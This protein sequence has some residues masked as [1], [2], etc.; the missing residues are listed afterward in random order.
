MRF[1]KFLL[2]STA[3]FL[4]FMTA[5]FVT[6]EI[7]EPKAYNYMV[8]TFTAHKHG[9]SRIALIVI[10]DK[11]IGR[12]RWPWKRN[13]YCGIYDYFRE[14]TNAKVVLSDSIVTSIDDINA[15]KEYF[16]SISKSDNLIVGI[17]FRGREYNNPKIGKQYDNKINSKFKSC[18]VDKRQNSKDYPFR[19]ASIFPDGYLNSVK[20][21]GIITSITATDG[22]IRVAINAINYKG[23][24]Y[25]SISL[26]AYS[27]IN[28]DEQLTVT[29]NYITGEKSGLKIPLINEKSGMYSLIKFYKLNKGS[30]SYSHKTYSAVDIMDS[31]KEL[32]SG[33][34]P[35]IDPKEFDNKYIFVG[36]NVKAAA[37]GLS[38][39][40]ETPMSSDHSGL[41]LQ[42]TC[43]DNLIN[44][45][46][47]VELPG[48]LNLLISFCL[49]ILSFLTIRNFSLFPAILSVSGITI[50]YIA[51]CA[52]LFRFGIAIS[53]LTPISMVIITM[54]FAYSHK[55]ILED[56]NKE[57]IKTAMGKYISEDIMKNVVKNIDEIKL[58]GKKAN[59]TVL[60]ADIRGFTS[61]SEK[62]T[63]DE[64]SLILNEYFTEIEPIVTKNNGVINKFIGDAVMAIFGE[65]IQDEN[66]PKNAVRC[67][68]QMLDKVKELQKK[69]LNEGK[70]KIEI[71]IGVNTGEAFVGNIGSE[72][73]MEYTVIG[74][75][76]NLASRIEGNNKIYK[77]NLL[78]SSSTYAHVKSIVDVVK[79]SNVKIRGKEKEIDLYE[80]IKLIK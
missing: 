25:P 22:Y 3:I 42:A 6:D 28:G 32:K 50:I 29:D 37:T 71:G 59:V 69:W 54:I 2:I 67:A 65:P 74:D 20:K 64:V 77:T 45:D 44:H 57:K 79:I 55:Y 78:I 66:H 19:S 15:D 1:I 26:K 12:H 70:P 56:R 10:D 24:L 36:A 58:G 17:T 43:F 68:C 16:N 33:K 21:V 39:V 5:Y 53:I 63:A 48:W 60:F 47:M 80:V 35:L 52:V 31:Y 27:F 75:M 11:S 23:L 62:L 8:K 49:M 9:D 13:L 38:D 18:L 34:K 14:Y 51:I 30:G 72:K 76:V 40:K 73:R 4:F 7:F 61:M 46:F 41:D